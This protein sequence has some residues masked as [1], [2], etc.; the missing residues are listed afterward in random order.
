MNDCSQRTNRSKQSQS[1]TDLQLS[2]QYTDNKDIEIMKK[3]IYKLKNK[4]KYLGKK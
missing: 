4:V 3:Q 1:Y 2:T